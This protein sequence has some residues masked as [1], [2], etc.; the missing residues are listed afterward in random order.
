M[1]VKLTEAFFVLS[2]VLLL[3]GCGSTYQYERV[4][5]DGSSCTIVVYSA[6]DVQDGG[7]N[8]GKNCEVNGSAAALKTSDMAYEV[9]NN[10]VGKIP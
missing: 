7:L 9:I 1:W 3:S 6:R 8:I 2:W 10:L 4:L 5:A